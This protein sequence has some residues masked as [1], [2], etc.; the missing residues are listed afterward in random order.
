[1]W[2]GQK[3]RKPLPRVKFKRTA[4]SYCHKIN[5]VLLD[6]TVMCTSW[7]VCTAAEESGQS[8]VCIFIYSSCPPPSPKLFKIHYL[9]PS[10]GKMA[11][12][13]SFCPKFTFLW[14]FHLLSRL[15]PREKWPWL[16]GVIL[17]W[18]SLFMLHAL[19]YLLLFPVNKLLPI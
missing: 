18:D 19:K 11:G 17:A 13:E 7:L 16:R 6:V 10:G 12:E 14:L 1:M 2:N 5:K 15:I 3:S 4:H 8:Y 9:V